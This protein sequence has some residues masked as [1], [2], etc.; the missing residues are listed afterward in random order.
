MVVSDP[1]NMIFDFKLILNMSSKNKKLSFDLLVKK[2]IPLRWDVLS[3]PITLGSVLYQ[4]GWHV[5]DTDKFLP[6]T[7][8]CFTCLFQA[9]LFLL[10]FWSPKANAL[11][12]YSRCSDINAATHVKITLENLK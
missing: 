6:I 2:K 11:I 4:F 12:A 10:N 9:I 1:I 7:V 5:F 8:F 3:A